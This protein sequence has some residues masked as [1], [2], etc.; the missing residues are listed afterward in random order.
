VQG[1]TWVYILVYFMLQ[2]TCGA[3]YVDE[4]IQ[5]TPI[6]AIPGATNIELESLWGP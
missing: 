6:D 4:A 5:P 3:N 2:V 1:K